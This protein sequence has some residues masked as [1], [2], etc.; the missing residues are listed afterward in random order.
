MRQLKR[1]VEEAKIDIFVRAVKALFLLVI[2]VQ[3]TF[4]GFHI[5][6]GSHLEKRV[7]NELKLLPDSFAL[8]R[9]YCEYSSGI[10]IIDGKYIK[11]RGYKERIPFIYLID[12]ET[13]DILFGCLARAESEE[14]FLNIFKLL[15]QLNYPLKV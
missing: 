12:Y 2:I 9:D 13:H 5:L 7:F 10:L 6:M 3:M 14:A 15:K 8:T 1:A 11:V 4:F